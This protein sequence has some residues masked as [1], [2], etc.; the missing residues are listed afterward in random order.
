MSPVQETA[1]V[2]FIIPL[3]KKPL[4]GI[5]FYRLR[6]TDFDGTSTWSDIVSVLIGGSDN[7]IIF[8]NPADDFIRIIFPD[9][10]W[11]EQSTVVLTDVLGNTVLKESENI[12]EKD[13]IKRWT[14]L[15]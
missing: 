1:V 7:I 14:L 4:Q 2:R 8:P 10:L 11:M 12:S 13:R 5:S 9:D 6:Q 15:I 3:D